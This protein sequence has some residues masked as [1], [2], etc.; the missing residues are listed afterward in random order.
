MTV[1]VV[2]TLAVPVFAT[3]YVITSGFYGTKTYSN[4]D[5]LLMTGGGMVRLNGADN[6]TLNIQNTSPLVPTSGG[7]WDLIIGDNSHLNLSGGQIYTIDVL[8]TGVIADLSGGQISRLRIYRDYSY[9]NPV[10]FFVRDYDYNAITKILTGTWADYSTFR[11]QL[12][13]AGTGYAPT[14]SHLEFTIIP[15]PATMLL[16]CLGGLF[17]RRK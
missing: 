2:L 11:T 10:E 4:F 14:F 9:I 5:T 3:D 13:D 12:I 1:L 8:G 16:L 7:I 15:E 17:I 6:S